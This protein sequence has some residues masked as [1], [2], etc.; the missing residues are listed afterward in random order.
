VRKRAA[1]GNEIASISVTGL[2]KIASRRRIDS[3]Q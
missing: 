2:G 1:I 3:H